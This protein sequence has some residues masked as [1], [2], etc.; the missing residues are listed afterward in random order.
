MTAMHRIKLWL[1]RPQYLGLK[2]YLLDLL[3]LPYGDAAWGNS[4]P[5][6]FDFK[7]DAVPVDGVWRTMTTERIYTGHHDGKITINIREADDVEREKLR[8]DLHEAHRT[9]AGHFRHEIGH[10][11]WQM[12]VAGPEEDE[13]IQVFGDHRQQG[14]QPR[15]SDIVAQVSVGINQ[16]D[17]G[18]AIVRQV[19]DVIQRAEIVQFS[20]LLEYWCSLLRLGCHRNPTL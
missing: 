14:Q 1:E 17:L 2:L 10:Y 15:D 16:V 11:Y 9:L 18:A 5:L 6:S 20:D 3:Q 8:V 12:L 7:S 4:P 13:F 19:V